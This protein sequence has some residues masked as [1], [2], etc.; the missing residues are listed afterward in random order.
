MVKEYEMSHGLHNN[1]VIRKMTSL[2]QPTVPVKVMSL[3][4]VSGQRL[5]VGMLQESELQWV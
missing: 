3:L 2:I 4:L 1:W 5:G